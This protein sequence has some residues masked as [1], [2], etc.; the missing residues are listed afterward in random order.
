A[1]STSVVVVEILDRLGYR[2]TAD[3]ATALYA[4]LVTDTGSFR[5]AATNPAAH[6][7]AARLVAAGAD[8]TTVGW[9]VWGS[10][11]FRYVGLLGDVLSRARLEPGA[12]GGL[13]LAWTTISRADFAAHALEIEHVEG[14]IDV[15]WGVREAEVA[16]VCKET[17]GGTQMVSLRSRG[18]IDVGVLASRFGGGGHREKAGFD[19]P[20]PPTAIIE[21]IVAELDLITGDA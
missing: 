4:G 15:L 7:V 19:A 5:Q 13:G 12:A 18:R 9:S 21:S 1:A 17:P 2:L 10:H 20:G 8:P 11:G 3:V 14:V 6:E 16:A